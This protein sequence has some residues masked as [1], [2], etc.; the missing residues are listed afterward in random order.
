MAIIKYFAL[1]FLIVTN[2]SNANQININESKGEVYIDGYLL[3]SP[4]V[5]DE[6]ATDVID[7]GEYFEIWNK[8]YASV[9]IKSEV[10][11]FFNKIKG[12]LIKVRRINYFPDY[13]GYYGYDIDVMNDEV[14]IIDITEEYIEDLESNAEPSDYDFLN[15]KSYLKLVMKI[16]GDNINFKYDNQDNQFIFMINY[17][18]SKDK[19]LKINGYFQCK[20]NV[21]DMKINDCGRVLFL[22]R[23]IFLYNN[24]EMS[25]RSKMYLVKGDQ[26]V[27]LNEKS[28]M[29]GKKWYFVNYKGKKDINMWV[30]AEDVDYKER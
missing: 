28:D 29:F 4:L 17:L 19:P 9:K 18:K 21:G 8:Y 10:G 14:N 13:N 16:H 20:I 5:K 11:Y 3:K 7:K 1:F 26:I 6:L 2:L 12:K 30:N 25:G 15:K 27:I 23:K 24:P 22:K